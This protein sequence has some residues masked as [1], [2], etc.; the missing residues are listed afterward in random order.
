MI[1]KIES[2][3][4]NSISSDYIQVKGIPYNYN[5]NEWKIY[6]TYPISYLEDTENLRTTINSDFKLVNNIKDSGYTIISNEYIKWRKSKNCRTVSVFRFVNTEEIES[7]Y[8][9][10]IS[11]EI[12]GLEFAPGAYYGSI[13]YPNSIRIY[14]EGDK[15][16]K[17]FGKQAIDE[18]EPRYKSYVQPTTA[19]DKIIARKRYY[20]IK[21]NS[22]KTLSM[23]EDIYVLDLKEYDHSIYQIFCDHDAIS[24]KK[25]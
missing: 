1:Q 24:I 2:I 8:Q 15:L 10:H 20:D 23:K 16:T 18:M 4:F 7:Y 6:K 9:F 19:I 5:N 3:T 22:R 25:H 21:D 17:L 11:I 12:N 14:D 13:D